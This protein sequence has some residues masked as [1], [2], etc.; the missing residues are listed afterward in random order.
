MEQTTIAPNGGAIAPTAKLP[1]S[2][3]VSSGLSMARNGP[4][5]AGLGVLLLN[6][7]G[8]DQQATI[9]PFLNNIFSDRG[10]IELPGGRLGQYLLGRLIVAARLRDVKENYRKI[11]GASPIV[12]WTTI[13]MEGLQERLADRLND[14]PKVGMAMR[15]WHP[16]ADDALRQLNRAGVKHVIGLTLYPHYTQATTGS[17]QNDLVNARDRLGLDMSISFIREWYEQPG[18][19]DL[20]SRRIQQA[21]D[22]LT[23]N[24]RDRVQIVVSAHGLPQRFIDRGDPYVDHI[25]A[26]MDGVIK[27]LHNPPPTHLGFQSRTGPVRWIGPGTEDVIRRLAQSGHDALL[28][29]PIAFVSDHIETTFEVGMLFRDMAIE[30]GIQEYHVVPSFNDDPDLWNI[31]ADLVMSHIDRLDQLPKL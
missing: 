24:V 12:C 10:I 21:L 30:A 22:E 25:K 6:M 27:R 9:R 14:V 11:G 15:Y 28:V 1:N 19:L 5:S 7:G 23:P 26:T 31:L 3:R 4:E 20:W 29:W 2:R 17:S 13:Q 8:P 16:F 18:Y